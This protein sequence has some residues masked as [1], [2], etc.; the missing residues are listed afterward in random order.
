MSA[1][2]ESAVEELSGSIGKNISAL[3]YGRL[4][5]DPDN[6]NA[7]GNNLQRMEEGDSG[8]IS[9]SLVVIDVASVVEDGNTDNSDSSVFVV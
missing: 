4:E 1:D 5:T 7:S 9:S 3:T 8:I 2:L 6:V